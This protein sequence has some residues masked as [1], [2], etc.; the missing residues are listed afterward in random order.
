MLKIPPFLSDLLEAGILHGDLKSENILIDPQST[1]IKLIDFGSAQIFDT[2][3]KISPKLVRRFRGTSLYIPPEYLLNK[4]FYP[5]PFAVWTIGIIMY[6]MLLG[7]FPF[8][9][10]LEILEHKSKDLVFLERALSPEFKS[11]V[12]R[13]L[14]FYV[15]DRICIDKILLDPWFHSS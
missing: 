15:A 13:C 5:R 9:N 11:L 4:C 7:K 2:A 6:D 1:Q 12:K 3:A 14:S 8:E 10:D